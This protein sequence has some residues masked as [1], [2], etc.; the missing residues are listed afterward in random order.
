MT[1]DVKPIYLS[2]C[3]RAVGGWPIDL[4]QVSALLARAKEVL[5]E[6]D[7]CERP[8]TD[9]EIEALGLQRT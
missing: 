7:R 5:P 6:G 4:A 9:E 8:L 3:V 1:A 2:D